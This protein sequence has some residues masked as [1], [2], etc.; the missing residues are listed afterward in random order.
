MPQNAAV[1]FPNFSRN[2][3]QNGI[4]TAADIWEDI[5]LQSHVHSTQ[6]THIRE[7]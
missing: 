4:L 3:C 7:L 6:D 2:H 5:E 1:F